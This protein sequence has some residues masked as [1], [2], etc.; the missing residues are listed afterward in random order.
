MEGW[1]SAH[2]NSEGFLNNIKIL[3]TF[4]RNC[5][6]VNYALVLFLFHLGDFVFILK[7]YPMFLQCLG[8]TQIYKSRMISCATVAPRRIAG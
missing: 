2:P 4:A 7:S 6:S 8:L 1:A 3:I 5:K